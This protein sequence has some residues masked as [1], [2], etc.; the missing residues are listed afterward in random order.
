MYAQ[1]RRVP[2]TKHRW[3]LEADSLT[4]VQA[5]SKFLLNE[6]SRQAN[7][8]A[9]HTTERVPKVNMFALQLKFPNNG[10]TTN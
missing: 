1:T 5:H 4:K 10:R 7:Q 9:T 6:I 3:V 2:A 8:N